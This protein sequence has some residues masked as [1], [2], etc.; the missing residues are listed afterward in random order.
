MKAA[1][2]KAK[3]E[4]KAAAAEAK[5]KAEKLDL[6]QKRAQA[7]ILARKLKNQKS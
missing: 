6:L 1:I 4:E 3:E 5:R 7:A 2:Q